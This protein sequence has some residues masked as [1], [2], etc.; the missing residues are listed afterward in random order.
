MG[1]PNEIRQPSISPVRFLGQRNDQ[2]T[3]VICTH[4]IVKKT[5]KVPPKEIEKAE[6]SMKIYFENQ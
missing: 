4:G 2:N 3:L 1:T 6:T 5:D